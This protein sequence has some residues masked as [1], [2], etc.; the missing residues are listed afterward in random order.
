MINGRVRCRVGNDQLRPRRRPRCDSC[1]RITS[2]FVS[3]SKVHRRPFVGSGVGLVPQ[4]FRLIPRH[5]ISSDS[6]SR[7]FFL[8][9][10]VDST[11]LA[12][13]IFPRLVCTPRR[14]SSPSNAFH[15]W[16]ITRP[17]IS[18]SRKRQIVFSSGIVSWKSPP[19]K[20][21][22]LSRSRIMNPVWASER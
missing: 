16:S 11:M 14:F 3:S 15:N 12:S 18:S 13:T 17:T 1:S 6:P 2:D 7:D 4:R 21:M 19:M 8:G 22:K 5:V 20:R 10:L 9:L